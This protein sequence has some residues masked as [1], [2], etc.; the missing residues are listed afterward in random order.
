MDILKIDV[1]KRPITWL[2]AALLAISA[3]AAVPVVR[4]RAG[5]C[6]SAI[7]WIARDRA[8]QRILIPVRGAAPDAHSAVVVS[9]DPPAKTRHFA[10]F[11]RQRPPPFLR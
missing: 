7:V 4:P 2:L 10:A 6:D 5:N 9:Y 3:N 11:L 1:N 8:E